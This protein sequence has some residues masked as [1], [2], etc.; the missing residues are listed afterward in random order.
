MASSE[1]TKMDKGRTK[2]SDVGCV[3]LWEIPKNIV[4]NDVMYQLRRIVRGF[5]TQSALPLSDD[6]FTPITHF[7]SG[8]FDGRQPTLDHSSLATI[9]QR[10]QTLLLCHKIATKRATAQ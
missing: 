3:L 7:A 6:S 10:T 2:N 1:A 9:K 5:S 4:P 8:F